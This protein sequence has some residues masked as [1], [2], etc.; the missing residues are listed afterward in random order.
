M[1]RIFFIVIL[2]TTFYNGF[3]QNWLRITE[4]PDGD[5]IFV[6]DN[7]VKKGG[8][9]GNE[10][11]VVRVWTKTIMKKYEDTPT[12]KVYRSAVLKSLGEY[13]CINQKSRTI[14]AILYDSKGKVIVKDEN[15]EYDIDW[16]FII[17]ETVGE[18]ILFFICNLF[19]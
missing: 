18:E 16:E 17:P 2:I 11:G 12:G 13:D 15:R 1:K 10:E 14:T 5:T 9:I 8:V 19:K 4:T 7:Y 3:S 6:N